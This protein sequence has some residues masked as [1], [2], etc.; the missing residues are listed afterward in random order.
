MY[1]YDFRALNESEQYNAVWDS[2]CIGD[3]QEPGY[4]ILL[5]C[6]GEFYVEVYFSVSNQA[7]ERLRAFKIFKLLVP[8][9]DQM[10]G[11]ETFDIL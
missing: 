8:Y 4:N 3:R 2:P 1:L 6:L 5:Y 7:I 11:F 10:G 9:F